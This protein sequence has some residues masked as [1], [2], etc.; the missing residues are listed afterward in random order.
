MPAVPVRKLASTDAFVVVDLED[1]STSMGVVRLAPKIL[2]D[3]AALLARSFTYQFAS[4]EQ[5]SGGASAGINAKPDGRDAAIAAFCEEL[6]PEVAAGSLVLDAAKGLSAKELAPL[7]SVDVRDAAVRADAPTLTARSVV[8]AADAQLGG[9]E[10]RTAAIEGFDEVGMALSALLT[11]RGARVVRASTAGSAQPEGIE[12]VGI[13]EVLASEVDVLFAGSKAGVID[14]D[15][16]SAV[17]AGVVVPSGRVPV[18]AKALAA[19]RRAG[20]A[21]VP[22]FLSLA[23]PGLV[24]FGAVAAGDVEE[25]VA[26]A[27]AEVRAHDDGPLLG[28]CLR[29]EAFLRTWQDELPFG[30]PIA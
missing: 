18:T 23:G 26:G 12:V 7:L 4:F 30:R 19:L 22:D 21:V 10:G 29:A 11:D 17:R 13:E 9:L 20:T 14:H 5:V 28:A 8:A 16:A 24:A 27:V 2:A 1:A 15:N 25:R 6:A 3:G